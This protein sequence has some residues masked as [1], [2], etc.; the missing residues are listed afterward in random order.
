MDLVSSS[1]TVDSFPNYS[2]FEK[3]L[4]IN[5]EKTYFFK[6]LTHICVNLDFCF[7]CIFCPLGTS[8]AG[9][10]SLATLPKKEKNKGNILSWIS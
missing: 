7:L 8:A 1:F 5:E 10:F 2:V 4:T 9:R 6:L 3:I